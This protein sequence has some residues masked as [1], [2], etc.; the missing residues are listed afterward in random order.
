MRHTEHRQNNLTH[1][2]LHKRPFLG[3]SYKGNEFLASP[4]IRWASLAARF[5]FLGRSGSGRCFGEW[6]S[7]SFAFGCSYGLL[8]TPGV[9]R[10][11]L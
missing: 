9:L 2:R 3:S 7:E 1:Y 10:H 8:L 11:M 4:I 6:M 5:R